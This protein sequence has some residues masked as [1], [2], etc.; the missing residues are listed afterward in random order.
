MMWH[1]DYL[2]C[3]VI[4]V[5]IHTGSWFALAYEKFLL[6]CVIMKIIWS[7]EV[8]ITYIHVMDDSLSSAWYVKINQKLGNGVHM[9]QI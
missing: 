7:V 3:V 4:F 6:N 1:S 2:F 8:A 5:G 9:T